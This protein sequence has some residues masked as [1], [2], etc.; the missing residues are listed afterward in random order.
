[1]TRFRGVLSNVVIW[2]L[3]V[4]LMF[5]MFATLEICDRQCDKK[6]EEKLYQLIQV[7]YQSG[8]SSGQW[9]LSS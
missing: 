2:E 5:F 8:G 6:G 3:A 1:M 7:T 9:S 4:V